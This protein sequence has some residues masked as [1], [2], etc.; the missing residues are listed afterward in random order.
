MQVYMELKRVVED[1]QLCIGIKKSGGG[2]T[3]IYWNER[4]WW[5]ADN[6]LL[7]LK[8]VVQDRQLCIRIKVVVQGR[9]LCTGIKETG[10]GHTSMYWN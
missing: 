1:R 4:E 8:R 5:R 2:Q 3:T 7:E 9:H 10:T 6:Y